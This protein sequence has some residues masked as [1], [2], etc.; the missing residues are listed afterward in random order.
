MSVSV[1]RCL[2]GGGS[3]SSAG[4]AGAA[5]AGM[6]APNGSG[7][8]GVPPTIFN[9]MCS[10]ADEF[11]D[12]FHQHKRHESME[13]SFN[14]V[15]TTLTYICRPMIDDWVNAQE[16]H[17]TEHTD[18]TSMNPILETDEVLWREVE[19]TFHDTWTNTTSKRSKQLMIS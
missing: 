9:G 18:L 12:Q 15:L 10:Q 2:S 13:H 17:L 8:R 7:M 19:T 14:Q 5:G 16:N 3:G 4:G 6:A 11:W 1:T